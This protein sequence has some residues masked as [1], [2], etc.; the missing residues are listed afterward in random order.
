MKQ[1]FTK[2]YWL[3][4]RANLRVTKFKYFYSWQ[5]ILKMIIA[6]GFVLPV[7]F[8]FVVFPKWVFD[9]LN[10]IITDNMPGFLKID[11]NPEYTKMNNQQWRDYMLSLKD[12][13]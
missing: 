13:D 2:K 12:W 5:N 3:I 7:F 8:V 6:F 1:L 11:D 9:T 4:T 10:D